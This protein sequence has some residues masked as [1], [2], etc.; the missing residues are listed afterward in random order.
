VATAE[1]ELAAVRAALAEAVAELGDHFP[2]E[3]WHADREHRE[4][5]APWTDPDWNEARTELFLAA[6]ALHREFLRCAP[7]PVRQGLRAAMDVV[8]GVVPR[9]LPADAALAAWQV[10]FLVAPVAVTTFAGAGTLFGHL[11]AEALGRLVVEDAGQVTPQS[12]VGALWRC[13][14]AVVVGDPLQLE[15][16]VALPPRAERAVRR[17]HGVDGRWSPGRTSAQR[18]AD[19]LTVLGTRLPGE[20]GPLWVGCPLTVHRRCDHPMFDVVNAIAYDGLLINATAPGAAAAFDERHPRLPG[21]TWFDVPSA[22]AQGHWIPEEGRRLNHLLG[23]L[24]ETGVGP[25]DILVLA[26]FRDVAWRLRQR[27]P[28]ARRAGLVAGTPHTA[29]RRQADVVILV[30]GGDPSRPAARNWVAARPNLLTSAVS[31]ARHRLYVIGDR[32]SWSRR[33]YFAELSEHLARR[34]VDSATNRSGD[35]AAASGRPAGTA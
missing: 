2:G 18:L 32:R 10:Y 22:D 12:V 33:R 13:R 28:D 23:L 6:L 35:G 15:P 31:R 24:S 11:G 30:L 25:A 9:D 26:P 29:R 4:R 5:V 19:G 20:D 17:D 21:S 1:A 16:V 7:D 8:S 14:R 3:R 34:P 27:L